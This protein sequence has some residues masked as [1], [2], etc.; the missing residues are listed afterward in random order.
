LEVF[1][2]DLDAKFWILF[3]PLQTQSYNIIQNEV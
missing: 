1:Q 3:T 2:Q